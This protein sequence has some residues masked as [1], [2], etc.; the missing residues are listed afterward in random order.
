VAGG[1]GTLKRHEIERKEELIK[2]QATKMDEMMAS[3]WVALS[4]HEVEL[5]TTTAKKLATVTHLHVIKDT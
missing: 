4:P 5:R 2:L 1:K 3:L